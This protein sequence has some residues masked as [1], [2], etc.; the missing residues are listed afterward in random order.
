MRATNQNNHP[1]LIL[2]ILKGPPHCQYLRVKTY[3]SIILKKVI[4]T[5][6][7]FWLYEVDSLNLCGAISNYLER[8]FLRYVRA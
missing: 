2:E 6:W 4:H 3:P 8:N 1:P 7:E 5:G